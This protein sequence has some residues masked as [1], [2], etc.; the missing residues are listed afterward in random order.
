MVTPGASTRGGKAGSTDMCSSTSS[1]GPFSSS[2]GRQ[3]RLGEE[4]RGDGSSVVFRF[5][6]CVFASE[7]LSGGAQPSLFTAAA[8][9][10]AVAKSDLKPHCPIQPAHGLALQP[11]QRGEALRATWNKHIGWR[12]HPQGRFAKAMSAQ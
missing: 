4:I 3:A 10:R 7:R 1:S 5:V 2:A 6:N 12:R 9:V 11:G 8:A